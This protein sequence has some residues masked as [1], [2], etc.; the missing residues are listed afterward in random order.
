MPPP[1]TPPP[2]P[3][4][5]LFSLL[6]KICNIRARGRGTHGSATARSSARGQ[7]WAEVLHRHG[8]YGIRERGGLRR[9]GIGVGCGGQTPNAAGQRRFRVIPA[10]EIE[11]RSVKSDRARKH[12]IYG[13][14]RAAGRRASRFLEGYAGGDCGF[15]AAAGAADCPSGRTERSSGRSHY[16]AWHHGRE[17]RE[18]VRACHSIPRE[19]SL[20]LQGAG[21]AFAF[22]P[23]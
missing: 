21:S 7:T 10:P 15:W 20:R 16:A 18:A 17:T 6:L 2:P 8:L 19:A 11:Q 13:R 9:A 5:L 23:S 1:P 3:P 22:N 14:R 12:I 4:L